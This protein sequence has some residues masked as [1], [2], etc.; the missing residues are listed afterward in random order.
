MTIT[1]GPNND[2]DTQVLANFRA[3]MYAPTKLY[4]LYLQVANNVK[5]IQDRE[6]NSELQ[7]RARVHFVRLSQLPQLQGEFIVPFQT[8]L[9][10]TSGLRSMLNLFKQ[11]FNYCKYAFILIQTINANC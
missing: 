10:F 6:Y 7:Q 8:I 4:N 1:K 3:N 2:R 11:M 9:S 5:S